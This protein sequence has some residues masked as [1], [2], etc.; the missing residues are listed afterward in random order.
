VDGKCIFDFKQQIVFL[1]YIWNNVILLIKFAIILNVIIL[2]T[3]IKHLHPL[4]TFQIATAVAIWVSCSL[5][6]NTR[7]QNLK[8]FPKDFL[9]KNYVPA[10]SH[11]MCSGFA[12]FSVYEKLASR[13]VYCRVTNSREN[14][15]KLHMILL[16]LYHNVKDSLRYKSEGRWFD[17]R[18]CHWSFSLT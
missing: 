12:S 17:S 5:P 6:G 1:L 16:I 15:L 18:S 14:G 11:G 7:I 4:F 2:L 3:Y 10:Y 9:H 8:C 13:Y